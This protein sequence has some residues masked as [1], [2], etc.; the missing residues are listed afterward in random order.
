MKK[1]HFYDKYLM[2][3]LQ[4][5]AI[6]VILCNVE[7]IV[8]LFLETEAD[9]NKYGFNL[10]WN[11]TSTRGAECTL[12]YWRWKKSELDIWKWPPYT[13]QAFEEETL[14]K[15]ENQDLHLVSQNEILVGFFFKWTEKRSEFISKTHQN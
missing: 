13:F 15:A 9:V 1:K 8:W 11:F 6:C 4:C 12:L 3:N 7:E 10:L 5:W 2:H 14:L